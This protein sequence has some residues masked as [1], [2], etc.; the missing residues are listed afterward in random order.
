M[1]I[2]QAASSEVRNAAPANAARW[3]RVRVVDT[4]GSGRPVDL[5]LP[6]RLVNWGLKM[7]RTFSPELKDT[8]VDWDA[9]AAM[10]DQGGPG[11]IVHVEDAEKHQT[12]DVW[13]E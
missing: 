1:V 13:T 6:I 7:A 11:E 10:V 9:I 3:L 12:V 5:K 2:E 4:S 8:N